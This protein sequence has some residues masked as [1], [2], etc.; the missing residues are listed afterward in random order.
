[1]KRDKISVWFRLLLCYLLVAFAQSVGMGIVAPTLFG[2][3]LSAPS[4]LSNESRVLM[5]LVGIL[6]AT[7]VIFLIR[8]FIDRKTVGSL[9]LLDERWCKSLLTGLGLG[10]FAQVVIFV[11]LLLFGG[12]RIDGYACPISGMI[13][14][15]LM[16]CLVAWLE[17]LEFRAYTIENMKIFGDW[18]PI[19]VSSMAFVIPHY[20]GRGFANP[21]EYA[22]I[23]IFGILVGLAYLK[24][25]SIYLPLGFHVGFNF[26]SGILFEGVIVRG[27]ILL[28]GL[29]TEVLHW[30]AFALSIL[31]LIKSAGQR[32]GSAARPDVK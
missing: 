5:L 18:L 30:I 7:I 2:I 14:A 24:S 19:V 32:A 29:Q 25:G 3:D 15:L 8:R 31:L 17:E 20:H 4:S 10:G 9:G 26:L 11:L 28:P 1:M 13:V 21:A 27:E 16:A 23:F 22:S 6:F 12:Y